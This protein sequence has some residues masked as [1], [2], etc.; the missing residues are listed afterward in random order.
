MSYRYR[1]SKKITIIFL[2]VFKESSIICVWHCWKQI[3]IPLAQKPY[4]TSDVIIFL[5]IIS[6]ILLI[7]NLIY[8]EMSFISKLWWCHCVKKQ[9][10]VITTNWWQFRV[11][12][13]Y[14]VGFNCCVASTMLK[15]LQRHILLHQQ[16]SWY[17]IFFNCRHIW[18]DSCGKTGYDFFNNHHFREEFE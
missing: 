17:S 7:Y 18:R 13:R 11:G 3:M 14:S 1:N 8:Y 6:T 4:Q 2:C 5:K 12:C 10:H 9:H 16:S 15:V